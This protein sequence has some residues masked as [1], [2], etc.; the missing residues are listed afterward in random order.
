[1]SVRVPFRAELLDHVYYVYS[2]LFSTLHLTFIDVG[3][4]LNAI[5]K[6]RI[7]LFQSFKQG[8]NFH[9]ICVS[10]VAIGFSLYGC[11]MEYKDNAERKHTYR[12]N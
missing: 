4:V 1:M 12:T 5:F 8:S 11:D 10:H 7:Y 3:P 6:S 2:D 9:M